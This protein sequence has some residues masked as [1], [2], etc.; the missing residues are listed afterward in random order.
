MINHSLKLPIS[1]KVSISIFIVFWLIIAAFPF[2]W[3]LWGS[4][5]IEADFFSKADWMNALFAP[6]Y[7]C[8]ERWGLYGR[9]LLWSL[10]TREFLASGHKYD[11]GMLLCSRDVFNNRDTR[12]VCAFKIILQVYLLA[13]DN[14]SYF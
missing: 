2:I 4:F 5:K 11:S 6:T 10:G 8:R 7:Y 1:L 3:T 9:W 13:V 12:R 14:C